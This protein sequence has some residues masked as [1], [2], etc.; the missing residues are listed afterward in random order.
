MDPSVL[1]QLNAGWGIAA[2]RVSNNAE[3]DGRALGA[4]I[5]QSMIRADDGMGMATLN[6]A[7]R[8]PTTLEH[9]PYPGY[10]YPAQQGAAK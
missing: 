5:W 10:S 7:A 2:Q 4:A 9:P 8:T 1:Q 3:H 6:V